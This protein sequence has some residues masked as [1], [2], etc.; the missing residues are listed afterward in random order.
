MNIYLAPNLIISPKCKIYSGEEQINEESIY[1][2]TF[3]CMPMHVAVAV[4]HDYT[5][6]V[7]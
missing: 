3:L 4:F 7:W 6:S 5:A 1:T 2:H